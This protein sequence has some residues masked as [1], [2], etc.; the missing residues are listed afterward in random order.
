[1][2]CVPNKYRTTIHTARTH[3]RSPGELPLPTPPHVNNKDGHA[4]HPRKRLH[5]QQENAIRLLQ[6]K[7]PQLQP[8]SRQ[9]TTSTKTKGHFRRGVDLDLTHVVHPCPPLAIRR[10][11]GALHLVRHLGTCTR[12]RG[13]SRTD[14]PAAAAQQAWSPTNRKRE[15]G[16]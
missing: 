10:G 8:K 11:Y 2:V 6:I 9:P 5:A 12:R 7:T 3:M 1:M 16:E 13:A 15:Q 4:Y 14:V